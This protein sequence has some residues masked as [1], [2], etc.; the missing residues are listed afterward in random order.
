MGGVLGECSLL[1]LQ[2]VIFSCIFTYGRELVSWPLLLRT[3][4]HEDAT[5]MKYLPPKDPTF[6]YYHIRIKVSTDEFG[7]DTKIQFFKQ[8]LLISR[9]KILYHGPFQ[10]TNIKSLIMIMCVLHRDMVITQRA[11]IIAKCH[12]KLEK[13]ILSVTFVF[14]NLFFQV[15]AIVNSCITDFQNLLILVQ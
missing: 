2:M 8:D 1:G 12:K 15:T 13:C 14:N 10:A 3:L 5:V 7:R 6:R 4:I 9:V 11:Q